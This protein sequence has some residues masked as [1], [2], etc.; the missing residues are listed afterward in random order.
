[1]G[2]CF[3][4]VDPNINNEPENE[5]NE[6][7]VE[8]KTHLDTHIKTNNTTEPTIKNKDIEMTKID[9]N[10]PNEPIN[11]ETTDSKI[12]EINI[13]A[14][15]IHIDQSGD[16][17]EPENNLKS[18][19]NHSIDSIPITENDIQQTPPMTFKYNI[20]LENKTNNKSENEIIELKPKSNIE[21][22]NKYKTFVDYSK[23]YTQST[24]SNNEKPNPK[25]RT[26][27]IELE[28]KET[29]IILDENSIAY[30]GWCTVKPSKTFIDNSKPKRIEIIDEMDKNKKK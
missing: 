11:K 5:T 17:K 2:N 14:S 18:D 12:D 23:L 21:N 1:M 19:S 7:H 22:D 27:L 29:G 26:N 3:T 20:I 16:I 13:S 30:G 24:A 25:N 6:T 28:R 10:K 4:I 15:S 8:N 9:S